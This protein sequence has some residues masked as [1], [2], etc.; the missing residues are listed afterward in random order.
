MSYTGALNPA[1]DSYES[2]PH[3]YIGQ[4]DS[5][6][7]E[8]L[9][10]DQYTQVLNSGFN[11]VTAPITNQHFFQRVV[12]L[13]KNFLK[14][15]EQWSQELTPGQRTNPSMPTPI[16]PTLSNEDTSI[17]PSQHIGSL[18][19]YSSPWID[20]C[21]PDK[22]IASISRQV[23]NLEVAYAN[24]CGARS[25]VIPGP[26]SDED[27]AGVRQYA[28]AIQEALQVVTRANLIIHMPMY[29]EPGLEEKAETIS[30]IFGRDPEGEPKN[31]IDLYTSWD[32]WHTIRS[33]CE[34]SSRVFLA[35]RIPR[36]VPEKALQERWFAEPLHFLTIGQSVFQQNRAGHPSLSKHHQD[37]IN[38]YMRLKNA[39]WMI[40]NDVGPQDLDTTP[41]VKAI[42]YPSLSEAASKALKKENRRPHSQG[43]NEYVGYMKYLE[44]QQPPYSAMETPALT[45][46]Q[47]WLQSPLQPLADN[48]ES[49]TYE[50]FEGDPVKY[51]QY[52]TAITEAMAEWKVLKKPS[53]LGTESEPYNPELICAV[54]G[55][56]RGPLVARVLRAAQTTNTKIQLW[57]VEKNQNAFVY[58]LNRNKREWNN[59]V[60]L[61]K[62]DMRGWE[63]PRPKGFDNK[64]SGVDI[65]VTELLGS[66]GDNE[67]SPEC[68][69]G[70]QRHLFRPSGISIPL[71]YTAHLSPIAT[72]RLFA[73][74]A[75]RAATGDANAFEIP[76]VVR[77]F[78]LDFAAQ[79]VPGHPRFQQAWEFVH[80]VPILRADTFAEEKG[81]AVKYVTEGGGSM[82]GSSGTNE[83]NA[84]HCHL[85]FVCPTRGVIHGLAGYFESVLYASQL[86]DSDKEPVE[87]SILPDQIDKKSKDM[88]SWFPIFFPLKKPLMFPQDTEMEVSMW[89]Q[90]DDTKVWYEWMVEVYAW[91]G[92]KT[93]IKIN[94]SEMHS[95]R[96]V[97]CLM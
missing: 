16:V 73:E 13:H 48:L 82:Y 45:S 61:V 59:Q 66:F 58:L 80:P 33:V 24:F 12:D 84:R 64:I 2:R 77:L 88:I 44:R 57:A 17:Y 52:E 36:R 67:L 25:V 46:F 10:E 38:R 39:P 31:D 19:I 69:D 23:L 11:F 91:V 21:S 95:S 35:L 86:P 6:R 70:I 85:T 93:R 8:A 63:G 94:A 89:R 40:L 34:Y 50:V 20:L 37:L 29:R 43:I 65:L 68:L 55:A 54:A 7:W 51:D 71:S 79:K 9:D 92:P 18:I 56:G 76:Y 49:A 32:S 3:Y 47:D 22:H 87:I 90:T 81:L 62:T 5:D 28:R 60:T 15:Q 53:A 4:H 30:S 1:S 75:S 74:I 26:R 41:N 72:P 97:A 83:H 78:Q 27:A 96:K 42:E 14:E